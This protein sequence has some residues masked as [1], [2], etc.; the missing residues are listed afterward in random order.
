MKLQKIEKLQIFGAVIASA[1]MIFTAGFYFND[2]VNNENQS[3]QI[4]RFRS[5]PTAAK[6]QAPVTPVYNPPSSTTT[7]SIGNLTSNQ[8]ISANP[9]WRKIVSNTGEVYSEIPRES[10]E[11]LSGFC[12]NISDFDFEGG[13]KIGAFRGNGGKYYCTSGGGSCGNNSGSDTPQGARA[14]QLRCIASGCC[15]ACLGGLPPGTDLSEIPEVIFVPQN[16]ITAIK[17]QTLQ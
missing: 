9:V 6:N 8:A 10:L 1:V 4:L 14:N 13:Q 5:A 15:G 11:A 12:E 7:S 3:A 17:Q 2:K 16:I